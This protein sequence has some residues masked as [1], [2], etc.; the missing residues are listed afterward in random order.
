MHINS[1]NMENKLNVRQF[2]LLN[3]EEIVA[4]VTQKES[5]SFIVERPFLIRSNIVGG[6]VFLPWFPFSSQRIFK[7]AN[8]NILHHVEIDED[9]KTE[10]IKLAAD[11]R[12]KPK[13]R[14]Q[15]DQNILDELTNFFEDTYA[16]T[17][18]ELEENF[19]DNVIPFPNPKDTIH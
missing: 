4:L 8:E 16:E 19:G 6:F 15:V 14:P 12:M 7:I 10:Y 1:N 3:G 9:M 17:E 2:K 13:L 18:M 5:G 11:L